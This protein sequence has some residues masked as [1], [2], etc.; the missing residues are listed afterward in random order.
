M[1]GHV[2]KRQH[3]K[4]N[5]DIS[6]LYYAVVELPRVNGKRKSDWGSGFARK[7]DADAALTRKLGLIS[8]G[9]FVGRNS[10]TVEE[11]LIEWLPV[12]EDAV[13]ATTFASYRRSAELYLIPSVGDVLL[14]DL[15]PG[16]LQRLST[17][18]RKSGGLRRSGVGEDVGLSNKSVR[19]HL[20]VLGAALNHAVALG[21][22][23]S[24]PMDS[25][26]KPAARRSKEM[27]VWDSDEVAEFLCGTRDHWLHPLFWLALYS[28]ARRGELL[29]L[30]WSDLD[31]RA[32]QM[33]IRQNLVLVDGA[34]H[35]DTPKSHEA[36]TADL[37]PATTGLLSRLRVAQAERLDGIRPTGDLI[38]VNSDGSPI[39][40][41][42]TSQWFGRA[43]KASRIER[44]ITF[45]EMRHTH[46][47]LLLK[48]GVPI[49]VVSQ[50]LG[51]SDVGFTLKTY[52][53]VLP[54]QQADAA[55]TFA[56]LIGGTQA[57]APPSVVAPAT[58]EG[59]PP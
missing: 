55:R 44:R 42:S 35:F 47:T 11:L 31:L 18:L 4:K 29:G 34:L 1:R 27:T 17:K 25:V 24:N 19:N 9:E 32:G 56:A 22:I 48:A 6:T 38:F 36:R 12:A 46:A 23:S 41:D 58:G 30:R 39:R 7:K 50:R 3:T 14:R 21:Y 43:V 51:H 59:D 16:V 40:P 54:G 57:L 53:H 33:S 28:G 13:K 52:A 8:S 45:H 37:D 10:L 15:A 5:G 26:K 49:H 2:H 20:G